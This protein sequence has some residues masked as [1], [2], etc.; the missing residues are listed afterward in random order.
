MKSICYSAI[1]AK[2]NQGMKG[3]VQTITDTQGSSGAQWVVLKH[4]WIQS[5]PISLKLNIMFSENIKRKGNRM[6]KNIK[7][8]FLISK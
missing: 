5:P 2:I 3:G 6:E 1:E 8:T 7:I 4:F